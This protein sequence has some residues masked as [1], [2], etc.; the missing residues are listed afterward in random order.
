MDLEG[1][2][3]CLW[4]ELTIHRSNLLVGVIYAPDHLSADQLETYFESLSVSLPA[5]SPVLFVG[6]FNC[7]ELSNPRMPR[8]PRADCVN[9][10]ASF[11]GLAQC[12]KCPNVYGNLLDLVFSNC[13]VSVVRSPNCIVPEDRYHP[14]LDL[15]I[16]VYPSIRGPEALSVRPSCVRMYSGG[17]YVSL[18]HYFYNMNWNPILDVPDINAAVLSFTNV[19]V[20]ALSR[21]IPCRRPIRGKGY[22]FWF[23]P[24]LRRYL[25]L[26]N[27]YHALYRQTGR[28]YYHNIFS[29]LRK[30]AKRQY[31]ADDLSYRAATGQQLKTDPAKF[32]KHVKHLRNT[33][34]TLKSLWVNGRGITD[35]LAICG[36]L[37][38][39]FQAS[40]S[41]ASPM[42]H[43]CTEGMAADVFPITEDI[44]TASIAALRPSTSP[45]PDTIPSLIVKAY[46]D[47]FVPPLMKLFNRSLQ[48]GVFPSVW[49]TARIIPIFKSGNASDVRNYRP[50]SI[51]NAFT[52]VFE[53]S[54]IMVIGPMVDPFLVPE[55]H[56]FR[57][58]RSTVT[59][60]YAFA[61]YVTPLLESG[62]QVDSIYLDWE[63]AFDRVPHDRLLL[64]LAMIEGLSPYIK[65]FASYLGGRSCF[66]SVGGASSTAYRPASGVHQG[67]NLGPLLFN[68]FIND[69]PCVISNQALLFADDVKIYRQVS[70]AEDAESLQSDLLAVLEW[71][72]LN[73]MSLN[74]GKCQVVSFSRTRGKYC[75]VYRLGNTSL[76]AVDEVKDLGVRLSSDLRFTGYIN[77]RVGQALKVLGMVRAFS[78][79]FPLASVVV[80][81][82]ALVRPLLEYGTPLWNVVSLRD[83]ARIERVQRVFV[84]FVY[85][86]Y[87][88]NRFYYSYEYILDKLN[89][90]T[91]V[92]R[93]AGLETVFFLK[94]VAGDI[95]LPSV[96][97]QVS[98]L[99]P[100]RRRGRLFS[101][102]G[103]RSLS[104]ARVGR[105]LNQECHDSDFGDLILSFLTGGSL[106]SVDAFAGRF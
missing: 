37:A 19:V 48:S 63:K 56:G 40:F 36:E 91:L 24:A 33:G 1:A 98:L 103:P 72:R 11:F 68:I 23:T 50:I 43:S 55:Q 35:P 38:T 96:C 12:N 75:S 82:K 62:S 61:S 52:K 77:D 14:T 51:C 99:P 17:D 87:F 26:K 81:F 71:G 66:V 89:L 85:C 70:S 16:K 7:P 45:G 53:K 67:S 5:E 105:R 4:V 41:R 79:G 64:K 27:R 18:Y 39:S 46:A 29:I 15:C 22:P 106:P 42:S 102:V 25:K 104:L 44:V 21:F 78:R 6:D 9:F 83:E 73:G 101:V 93:R 31:K 13:E 20:D 8:S 76:T 74:A 47:L 65:W 32:W 100:E 3:E 57:R 95:D 34:S 97:S 49:N 86:R 92:S 58:N 60:L 90:R 54:L 59:N 2:V 80:L 30:L 88:G 94:A 10:V 69:L 28:T 84:R